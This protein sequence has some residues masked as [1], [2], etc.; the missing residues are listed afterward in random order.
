MNKYKKIKKDKFFV[1]QKTIIYL[2]G[3]MKKTIGMLIFIVFMAC[4]NS[5]SEELKE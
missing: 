2:G 1:N 3:K 5:N 4:S